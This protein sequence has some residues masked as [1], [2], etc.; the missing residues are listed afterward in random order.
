MD[1]LFTTV[2]LALFIGLPIY[3]TARNLKVTFGKDSAFRRNKTPE[4]AEETTIR[5]A[6]LDVFTLLFGLLCTYLLYGVTKNISVV[7]FD[8]A[9][10]VGH[11]H[12]PFHT[13]YSGTLVWIMAFSYVALIILCVFKPE[14]LSPVVSASSIAFTLIGLVCLAFIFIQLRINIF[15]ALYFLNVLLIAVRRIH[16]HITE[17]VRLANE[18][19]TQFRNKAAEKLHKLISKISGM[20]AFSFLLIFPAAGLLEILFILIGQGPD[21]FIKAFTMTADWTFS[22]QTPPPPIEYKGHYL[23][24]VAARGHK[25]IVKPLRYGNRLG[26]RI[27]VNRQ[28]L[29]ANAFEDMIKEK[30]PHFHKFVRDIYDKYGYPVSRHIT[31]KSRADL[32]YIIMKPLEFIFILTLY[33]FDKNPENRIAVQYSDYNYKRGEI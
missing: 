16:F 22:T 31:T 2:F 18:R 12:S 7:D 10:Y 11:L 26:E 24:T 32:T 15:T 25:K 28:L 20:T 1:M 21:G 4:K 3:L 23:C 33:T 13:Q 30:L 17:H 9:V 5:A 27:I 29:A 14:K 8:T 6:L 19:N